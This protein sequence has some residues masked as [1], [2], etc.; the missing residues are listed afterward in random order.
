MTKS[1]KNTNS[2]LVKIARR[3]ASTD[4][5]NAWQ[6]GGWARAMA[7]A[8]DDHQAIFSQAQGIFTVSMCNLHVE[9]AGTARQALRHWLKLA[10]DGAH[11]HHPAQTKPDATQ[12]TCSVIQ[13]R[14]AGPR[15][16][17]YS[18]ASGSMPLLD[19]E[20]TQ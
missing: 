9:H 16:D 5:S 15:H 3:D 10:D 19:M 17:P 11:G 7:V 6:D 1:R 20:G 18:Y 2:R 4:V 12:R 13:N 8:K 14:S